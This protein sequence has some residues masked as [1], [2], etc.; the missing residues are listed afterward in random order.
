MKRLKAE[1]VPVCTMSENSCGNQVGL[2]ENVQNRCIFTVKQLK[3]DSVPVCTMS[4]TSCYIWVISPENVQNRCTFIV[5]Q[6]Q[7]DSLPVCKICVLF[8]CFCAV[9]TDAGFSCFIAN[10]HQFWSFSTETTQFQQEISDITICLTFTK[11]IA[12]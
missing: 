2:V 9:G 12:P 5:K 11:Q 8:V 7:S 4:E 1:S 3:P 10:A 6:R